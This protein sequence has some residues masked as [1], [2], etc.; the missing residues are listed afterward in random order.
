MTNA[1]ESG[2]EFLKSRVCI[3]LIPGKNK[4]ATRSSRI[5]DQFWARSSPNF[6]EFIPGFDYAAFMFWN[7]LKSYQMAIARGYRGMYISQFLSRNPFLNSKLWKSQCVKKYF[8]CGFFSKK[9]W[10]FFFCNMKVV[11]SYGFYYITKCEH[12]Y[13]IYWWL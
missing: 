2:Y 10:S 4:F 1:L 5:N 11:K 8:F 6:K 3:R 9:L 13:S 7:R 12:L